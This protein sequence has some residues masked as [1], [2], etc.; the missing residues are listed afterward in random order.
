MNR[1]IRHLFCILLLSCS[2]GLL[3]SCGIFNAKEIKVGRS[4]EKEALDYYNIS[5]GRVDELSF[6]TRNFLSS[7][8]LLDDY[9][10]RPEQ[11]V[12]DLSEMYHKEPSRLTLCVLTDVCF[13][14]SLQADDADEAA[15]YDLA[16]VLYSYQLLFNRDFTTQNLGKYD[17]LTY[18]AVRT[19]NS[20]LARLYA[21]LNGK[22]LTD[23]GAYCLQT[24]DGKSVTFQKPL[25]RLPF[26]RT[27]YRSFPL[28]SDFKIENLSHFTHEF[29]L[30]VPVVAVTSEN[31]NYESLK[32]GTPI[33][34]GATVFLRFGHSGE[35]ETDTF[36]AALEFYDNDKVRTIEVAGEKKVPLIFDYSTPFAFYVS[37]LP[38]V[39]LLYYMLNPA[40]TVTAP[41]LYTLEPYNPEKIPVILIHGLMSSP[42]TWMQMVNTLKNDPVIREN[43]QF[44]FFTYSSGN[45]IL[46]S[47][48]LFRQSLL[49]AQME[50]AQTPE[51]K[52]SFNKMV[53]IGHSMG[54]LIAKTALLDA[55][56]TL[57]KKITGMSWQE[58]QPKCTPEQQALIRDMLIFDSIPSVRRVLFLAVPH[59]GSAMAKYTIAHIGSS[60][61][62]LPGELLTQTHDLVLKLFNKE[63][64]PELAVSRIQTGIDGL[65]PDNQILKLLNETPFK[66][67]VPYHS[68]IGNEDAPNVPGGTDGIVSYSSSHLDGA[69]SELIVRSGHS[70][71]LHPVAI[72][73]VRRILRLHL[74]E[75]G[76]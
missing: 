15:K 52:E 72:H 60:L 13:N 70:V 40:Q 64:K 41:G 4:S 11:L 68:I 53:L 35:E 54:G 76:R 1:A 25:Y 9:H 45:P 16:A 36:S 20:A 14:L 23:N 46:Y 30:G 21:Y 57:L 69:Q 61:I 56:D 2:A 27:S 49:D 67:G 26:P 31:N 51:A 63:N 55:Q 59:R 29:G 3:C 39:N 37:T 22:G 10:F 8:L 19:Y 65:D 6:E 48:S 43:C 24:A 42:H 47:A 32:T 28:C 5:I 50:L 75:N 71:Q 18:Q 73:E 33:A 66:P 58:I 44:W 17:P 7:N 38:D 74:R 34:H 12:R 62:S